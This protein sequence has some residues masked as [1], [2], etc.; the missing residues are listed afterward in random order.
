MVS[1]VSQHE[2]L[3]SFRVKT[4]SKMKKIHECKIRKIKWPPPFEVEV[5]Q[6]VKEEI[7]TP[8]ESLKELC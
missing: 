3:S 6:I 7:E 5:S 4:K 8:K 1:S 2:N